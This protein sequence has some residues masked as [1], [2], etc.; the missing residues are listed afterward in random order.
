MSPATLRALG[1][2]LVVPALAW[3]KGPPPPQ[4]GLVEYAA[5]A[6]R[7][8]LPDEEIPR[9]GDPRTGAIRHL[10]TPTERREQ[11]LWRLL[12]QGRIA[13][14][15]RALARMRRDHPLWRP[16]RRLLGELARQ[17]QAEAIREAARAGDWA[18]LL[19]LA[20]EHPQRF[21]CGEIHHLWALAD[22]H[23]GL[24]EP[25]QALEVY[26]RIVARCD[27]APRRLVTLQRAERQV[28]GPQL[29]A[30]LEQEARRARDPAQERAFQDLRYRV[31]LR[32]ASQAYQQGR[33]PQAAS[34][35]LSLEEGLVARQ[36]ADAAALLG[37][38]LT[39][40][41]RPGRA[42]EWFARAAHWSGAPS[43]RYDLAL[44]H[45]EAGDLERA[46]AL[47][48]PLAG[49]EPRAARLMRDIAL[50]RA[51]GAYHNGDYAGAL[52]GLDE[53]RR[54]G[55]PGRGG[56]LLGAWSRY[57][58]NQ[59]G[60]AEARFMDLYRAEPDEEAARGVVFSALKTDDLHRAYALGE[61][62]GGRLAELIPGPEIGPLLA[63]GYD[64]DS[65]PLEVSPAGRLRVDQA[66]VEASSLGLGQ[67]FRNKSGDSGLSRLRSTRLP[68]LELQLLEDVRNPWRLRL[69]RLRLDSG[70]VHSDTLIGSPPTTPAPFTVSP[71]TELDQGLEGMLHYRHR[72]QTTLFAGI[73]F[74]PTGAQLSP[75]WQGRLGGARSDPGQGWRGMLFRSP[76]RESLLSYTGLRDP[77]SG[78]RWGRVLSNG[79]ALTVYH[80]LGARWTLGGSLTLARLGGQEV[81]ANRKASL[82]AGLSLDLGGGRLQELALG[83][84]VLVQT[85][86]ENLGHFTRGHGGYFSPQRLVN[87]GLGTH[88]QTHE[89]RAY[90][91]RARMDLG[92]QAYKEDPAPLFPKHPDGRRYA[93]KDEQ[94]PSLKLQLA[95]VSQIGATPWQAAIQ[96]QAQLAPQYND[97]GMVAY[98][99]Y[100]FGER[101]TALASD[102]P[103]EGLDGWW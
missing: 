61:T 91:V 80:A 87:L 54:W 44:A 94:G 74:T 63:R 19:R 39:K 51:Q 36:D 7:N 84:F 102:L 85:F 93:G 56:E 79:L 15:D 103:G 73:G 38:A 5:R 72:G 50:A 58:L 10:P 17:R 53:A 11:A 48:R 90:L 28:T 2:A 18:S 75:T 71:T 1:L 97:F 37:W 4:T 99:R 78:Q 101:R 14:L 6:Q 57:H 12:A 27:D 67:A 88:L 21:N 42:L 26:R 33:F 31:V 62:L 25:A 65:L 98:V 13:Q 55:D 29:E 86:A 92:F 82:F 46:Q 96:V 83:P 76:V 70:A 47:V 35:L 9:P 81:K 40:S 30:L 59:Y 69:D 3:A 52:G 41:H 24:G 100:L 23:H 68:L 34:R 8:V 49:G 32:R 89:R 77:Y 60:A 22:A 45:F 20:R 64:W 43:H 95:S 66:R 16:P